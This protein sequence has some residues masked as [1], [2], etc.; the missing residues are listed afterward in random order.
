MAVPITEGLRNPS[1]SFDSRS[2]TAV[3][4]A[5]LRAF[6]TSWGQGFDVG[7]GILTKKIMGR[8]AAIAHNIA[9]ILLKAPAEIPYQGFSE[10]LAIPAY[11]IPR[12]IWVDKPILSRGTWFSTTYLNLPQDTVTSSVMSVFGE[13]YMFAGWI[14]TTVSLFSLGLLLAFVFVNTINRGLV[15]VFLSLVPTFLDIEGQFTT[16][17]V[18]LVQKWIVFVVIYW[19]LILLSRSVTLVA[20]STASRV[21]RRR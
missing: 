12:A 7:W 13:P 9:I 1:E 3:L 20:Y 8:Q 2:L 6:E 19:V 4:G 11:I 21:N 17:V 18:I 5:A 14:G 16:L 10:F 15:P